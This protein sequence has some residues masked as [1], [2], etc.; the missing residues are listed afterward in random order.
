MRGDDR[1]NGQTLL[2]FNETKTMKNC[3]NLLAVLDYLSLLHLVLHENYLDSS[4]LKSPGNGSN[5]RKG[6]PS[7]ARCKQGRKWRRD[8]ERERHRVGRGLVTTLR[9]AD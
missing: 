1:P 9:D 5:G 8:Y 6:S 3:V 7:P 4:P 2:E